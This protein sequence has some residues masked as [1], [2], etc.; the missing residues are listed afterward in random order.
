MKKDFAERKDGPLELLSAGLVA[1]NDIWLL[2]V[3]CS[4]HLFNANML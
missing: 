1:S 3:I 4:Y 2:P